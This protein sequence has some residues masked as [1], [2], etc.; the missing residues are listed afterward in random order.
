MN[1]AIDSRDSAYADIVA[2]GLVGRLQ[3]SV[4]A[5]IVYHPGSTRAEVA[6]ILGLQRG[7][8]SARVK[9]LKDLGV[10]EERGRRTCRITGRITSI[11]F[12][13]GSKPEKP[14]KTTSCCPRCNG[15][16]FVEVKI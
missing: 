6:E 10:L 9:E 2:E 1:E 7:T 14:W 15:T 8:V 11:L 12:F 16:G 13:T 3:L 5:N 4:L